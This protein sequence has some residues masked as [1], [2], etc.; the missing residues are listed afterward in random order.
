MPDAV[1]F[2]LA[3]CARP[4]LVEEDAQ[5]IAHELG[6]LPVALSHAA[7]YLRDNLTAS[8]ASYRA[9]IIAHMR[10]APA[11]VEYGRAVYATFMQQIEQAEARAPGARVVLSLAA[12]YGPDDIP[13]EL[14]TQLPELYPDALAKVIADPLAYEKAVGALDKLSLVEFSPGTRT[15]SVHRLVQAAARDALGTKRNEW[16]L[17]AVSVAY[18]AFPEP[19]FETWQLCESLVAHVRAVATHVATEKAPHEL[20]WLLG[21]AGIYVQERAALADALPLFQ[22]SLVIRE[23]LANAD[24][25]N[26]GSQR[27]L[28]V[29]QD[30]IG[31]V[32]V[33]QGNLTEALTAYQASLVIRE[34][35][36]IHI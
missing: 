20:A 35:S 3:E 33:A 25:G 26:A 15:F 18:E 21:T 31:N 28:S 1:K 27:G 14:F 8:A 29:S 6:C 19:P 9:A 11:D 17:N 13:E 32:L 10:E 22:A 23:R 2:L 24:P 36:L 34:L 30:N 12:F 16:A 7:A 4:D 5:A